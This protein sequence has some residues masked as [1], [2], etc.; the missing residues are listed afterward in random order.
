MGNLVHSFLKHLR[1]AKL[2]LTW[3]NWVLHQMPTSKCTPKIEISVLVFSVK[4]KQKNDLF[5]PPP[6]KKNDKMI[7][8]WKKKSSTAEGHLNA[9]SN[10][11][12]HRVRA[13]SGK[14]QGYLMCSKGQQ[15]MFG[16]TCG[17][18]PFNL[19]KCKKSCFTW[20][21]LN[22]SGQFE[23]LKTRNGIKG[24]RK[25]VAKG[26]SCRQ[27]PLQIPKEESYRLEVTG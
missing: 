26:R 13:Q 5:T 10:F 16:Q 8:I 1:K 18:T 14:L 15:S 25:G 3:I 11:M 24:L 23:L 17:G 7:L 12:E 2:L 27:L 6:K 21:W 9:R 22:Y 19:A 20:T 4:F